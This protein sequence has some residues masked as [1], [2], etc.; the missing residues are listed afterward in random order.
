MAAKHILA[1]SALELRDQIAAGALSAIEVAEAYLAQ[2]AAR[3]PEVQAWAWHDPGFVGD[4]ARALDTIRS[5]GRGTGALHGV[6]VGLKDIIDTAKIPTENGCVVDQGRVPQH[7]AA[8]VAAL[9]R[10]GALIMGKT[11]TTELAFMHPT[12]TR[13]PG[14]LEHT[15]G[16]SSSGSA[17]A[18]ADAMVPLAVGTQTGG[19]VIRPASFCGVTGFKPTFGTISRA[20]VLRQSESLDTVG[21]FAR[22]PTDAALLTETLCGYDPND[23]ASSPGPKPAMLATTQS[24][25][26]LA[27]VFAFVKLPGWDRADKDMKNGFS[28]LVNAL[29]EQVFEAPL[30][31][32]F[33]DAAD[34]RAMINHAEMAK[35]FH[36]YRKGFDQLGPETREALDIG[37]GITAKD[38]L[39][40]R[41]W[42][43]VFYA[44]L[45]EI[46]ER[47]DAIIC[48]AALGPAPKG[49]ETTGDSIFNGL[50]TFCGTPAV[51]VP[52]LTSTSELP[53]GVQ[54]IAARDEDARLLRTAQWLYDWATE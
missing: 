17:A 42:K 5:K 39:S 16:G 40:A 6:P 52:I 45:S 41:D 49:L 4:Q 43:E 7:D 51:T 37:E 2:I 25:P 11:R 21:V 29:G 48:P 53:M 38:Y 15:P 35:N 9:K 31:N 27:P 23:P 30:P 44:G 36:R 8:L 28:E 33:S 26:P 19:S 14:N 24:K 1:L 3:E 47:A 10:A 18:V 20:G 46:F 32:A 34:L 12:T 13:N 50:W 22:T 54:L